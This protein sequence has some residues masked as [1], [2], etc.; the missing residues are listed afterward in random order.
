MKREKLR[1]GFK[2][3][4]QLPLFMVWIEHWEGDEVVHATV[5]FNSM[6]CIGI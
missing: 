5:K 2:G 3:Q 1:F 4:N 6:R